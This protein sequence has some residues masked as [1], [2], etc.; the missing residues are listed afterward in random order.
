MREY[1]AGIVISD[2][3]GPGGCVDAAG[4]GRLRLAVKDNIDVAGAVT[5]EGSR[6]V[7]EE[8][9]P[10]VHSAPVVQAL[11]DAGAVVVSKVNMHEF[12]YGVTS[13]NP[14]FGA[15]PNPALPGRIPGGSSGGSAAVIAGGAADIALGTDTSGSIRMPAGCVGVVGL[16]PRAGLLDLRG[17][18]PLCPSFDTVGPMAASVERLAWGWCALAGAALAACPSDSQARGTRAG[19]RVALHDPHASLPPEI[20]AVLTRSGAAIVGGQW[21]GVQGKRSGEAYIDAVLNALWPAF[22]F[23]A[24]RTHAARFPAR[25]AEYG[26][27]V[28]RKLAAAQSSTAADHEHS[29]R[30][31]HGLRSE[32]LKG[33]DHACIDALVLPTLGCPVPKVDDPEEQYEDALGRYAAVWSAVNLPALAIGNVQIVARTEQDVLQLGLRL[34]QS[35]LTPS[36]ARG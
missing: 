7:A 4:S 26:A 17:V 36:P 9:S 34:E 18:R 1:S 16:R 35:G 32:L 20:R 29:L 22:R 13:D 15:V 8:S 11:V 28:A 10:A 5:S 12:A 24:A 3:T 6:F 14:W 19:I 33:W 21:G 30:V 31:L 27:S 2:L 25:A 23:E